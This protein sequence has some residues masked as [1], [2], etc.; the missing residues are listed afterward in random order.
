MYLFFVDNNRDYL[1][2][3]N[4]AREMLRNKHSMVR[5]TIQ[6]EPYDEQIVNSSRLDILI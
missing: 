1:G 2:V 6:I 5:V 3:L 4:E